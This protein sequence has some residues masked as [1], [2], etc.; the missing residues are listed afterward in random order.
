MPISMTVAG[1][2]VRADL[3]F[4]AEAEAGARVVVGDLVDV[5]LEAVVPEDQLFVDLAVDLERDLAVAL[6]GRRR[7][8]LGDALF[9]V[10][11]AISPEIRC[12]PVCLR[13]R[14]HTR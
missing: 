11:T 10:G 4:A 12:L 13:G 6:A 14:W 9:E 8:E 5:I 7:L 3:R 2:P 1:L